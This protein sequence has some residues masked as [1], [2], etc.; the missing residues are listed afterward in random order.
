MASFWLPRASPSARPFDRAATA[1]RTFP[2]PIRAGLVGMEAVAHCAQ[3]QRAGPG[4]RPVAASTPAAAWRCACCWPWPGV[5]GPG[6]LQYLCQCLRCGGLRPEQDQPYSG[7]PGSM[8]FWRWVWKAWSAG[9]CRCLERWECMACMV[10]RHPHRQLSGRLQICHLRSGAGWR[11][12][13]DGVP[14]QSC[15]A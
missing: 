4:V 14:Q 11:A 13:S 7:E 10:Q 6:L 15:P 9:R 2:L 8:G 12:Q 3:R 5:Q 1:G